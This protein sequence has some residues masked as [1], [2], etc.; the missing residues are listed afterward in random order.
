MQLSLVSALLASLAVGAPTVALESLSRSLRLHASFDEGL[1]A[2][3]ARGDPGLRLFRTGAERKTGGI[4]A[5][6][7]DQLSIAPQAG[8]H[9]GALHRGVEHQGR[10]FYRSGDNLRLD[11]PE[12]SGTVS[13]WLRTDPDE[14]MPRAFCDPVMLIGDNHRDGFLFVEWSKD[15]APRRFR[16]AILPEY[17]RWNADDREWESIPDGERPM[18]QLSERPFGRDRWVHVVFTYDRLNAGE[19]ARGSL[20]IDGVAVGSIAGWDLT[21]AWDPASVIIA[22]AWNYVGFL[23][24]LAIFDRALTATEIATL[25]ALPEGVAD[26]R[27]SATP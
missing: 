19:A 5:T 12:L 25:H 10:L 15:H 21:L 1:T 13:V 4:A 26:L 6:V 9:G 27:D 8:R 7:G 20:Y 11:K 14:D 24:D 16:Y 23:D 17:A 2:D 22:L 18:V 3:Y